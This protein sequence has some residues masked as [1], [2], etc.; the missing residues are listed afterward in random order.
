MGITIAIDDFGTEYS[1]LSY[2]KKLPLNRI[3]IPKAF[4][5]GIGVNQKDEAI[6][7][8]IIVLA[9][10][11]GCTTIAEGVENLKQLLFLEENGCD[12]IQGYY[13]YQPMKAKR[14]EAIMIADAG[15]FASKS[16]QL[17]EG[18]IEAGAVN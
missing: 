2:L 14:I 4:V 13:F 17:K 18:V 10:K 5:D 7:V 3:K 1:S 6:I 15:I 11:L 16:D 8:S 9:I 12:E